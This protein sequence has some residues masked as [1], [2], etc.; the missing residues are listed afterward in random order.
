MFR[1]CL[2][3]VTVH[4]ASNTGFRQPVQGLGE[5]KKAASLAH[6]ILSLNLLA[7]LQTGVL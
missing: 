2:S 6:S 5:R 1:L 7:M 4:P 3:S